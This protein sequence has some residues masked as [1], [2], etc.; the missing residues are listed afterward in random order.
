LD[1]HQADAAEPVWVSRFCQWI[2]AALQERRIGDLLDYRKRAPEAGR[3][4]PTEEHFMPFFVALGA[5]DPQGLPDC[6]HQSRC[7]GSLRLDAYG[8]S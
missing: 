6:L 3:N 5:G 2:A 8:F 4:H 7:F 1:W